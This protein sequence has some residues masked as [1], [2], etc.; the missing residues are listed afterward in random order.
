MNNSSSTITEIKDFFYILYYIIIIL[1]ILFIILPII[2][3]IIY[4]DDGT[5]HDQG[6][7][8]D[9]GDD[10]ELNES[11]KEVRKE[12]D[13]EI[14]R[15]LRRENSNTINV[16]DED[17]SM[18]KYKSY[19]QKFRLEDIGDQSLTM[20]DIEMKNNIFNCED[21]K[22]IYKDHDFLSSYRSALKFSFNEKIKIYQEKLNECNR[23]IK[24]QEAKNNSAAT[25]Y[26]QHDV[27]L[28]R[29]KREHVE[30][31]SIISILEHRLRNNTISNIKKNFELIIYHPNK[32]FKSL[33]GRTEVKDFLALQ[34]YTFC[35]NP[36][37]F[38]RNFQNILITGKSGIGKTK[39][40]KTLGY[41][42]SKSGILARNKFRAITSQ[43]LTTKYVNDSAHIT[44]EYLMSCLEGILFIDEAYQL[45]AS[46][47]MDMGS[48]HNSEA[49]T[50]MVNFLD[51]N[52]GLSVVAAAGYRKEMNKFKNANKGLER[53]F[54]N[55]I[56]LKKYNSRQLTDILIKFLKNTNPDIFISQDDANTLYTLIDYLYE[57]DKKIF[58]KQAGDMQNL[59]NY[60]SRAIYGN[61]KR[62]WKNNSTKNNSILL[63]DGIQTYLKPKGILIRI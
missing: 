53:R 9:Y 3:K 1:L 42:Y 49:I 47:F 33:I 35:Q 52:V 46:S 24:L 54:P 31:V 60:L 51:K 48:S 32:G 15:E 38:F 28:E 12:I 26:A 61:N 56:H 63:L 37:V 62:T 7:N 13:R 40:A 55:D 27:T 30:Y 19:K 17:E 6:M 36:R 11:S 22:K 57:E 18:F 23:D 58:D 39:L 20:D 14:E 59:S 5:G 25:L 21:L 44:R 34:I 16:D 43:D 45:G 2:W 41:I 29:L 8:H 10:D 4:P 50:E